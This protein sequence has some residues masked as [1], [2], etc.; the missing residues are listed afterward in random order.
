MS[1]CH[2]FKGSILD[3]YFIEFVKRFSNILSMYDLFISSGALS[4]SVS[5][6]GFELQFE[7]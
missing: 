4:K 2:Y 6:I 3:L 7:K 1:R 5:T